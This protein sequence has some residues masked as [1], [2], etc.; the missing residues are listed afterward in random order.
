MI[1]N[2]LLNI[3]FGVDSKA[4]NHGVKNCDKKALYL[5]TLFYLLLFTGN[6]CGMTY[7]KKKR[8]LFIIFN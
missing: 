4:L 8:V 3:F 1:E 6:Q 7:L 2:E 5:S